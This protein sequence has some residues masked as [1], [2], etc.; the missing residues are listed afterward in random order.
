MA[1]GAGIGAGLGAL[2]CDKQ[3]SKAEC[4]LQGGLTGALAGAAGVGAVGV[5]GRTAF[6]GSKLAQFTAAGAVAGFSGEAAGQFMNGELDPNRLAAA[7]L[8]GAALGAGTYGA[9]RGLSRAVSAARPRLAA[10]LRDEAGELSL[11][12]GVLPGESSQ[13]RRSLFHYTDEEGYSGIN[14]SSRLNAS[15]PGGGDAHHGAGQYFTDIR[16]ERV[17]PGP[18]A[19]LTPE[20]L[21]GGF[22]SRWQLSS[23]LFKTPWK[24]PQL[25]HFLEIDVTDLPIQNPE[26]SI[27]LNPGADPLD[28]AGRIVRGGSF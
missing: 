19:G 26:G 5:V 18:K 28:L 25:T 8:G 13:P 10:G 11:G 2:T 21:A 4:A 15:L 27:F 3:A 16:P 12:R 14:S 6:A 22:M 7:T 20:Q 17:L 9:G 24:A 1:V 23:A